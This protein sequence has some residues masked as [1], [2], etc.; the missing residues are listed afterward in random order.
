MFLTRIGENTKAIVTGD[1][2]QIDLPRRNESGLVHALQILSN[3]DD[4]FVSRLD[5]RDVVRSPLVRKIIEA[6]E[7]E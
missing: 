3:V 1:I 4:I 6:Y 5:A 2:T 7:N